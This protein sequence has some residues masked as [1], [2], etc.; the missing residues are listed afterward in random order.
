M[1]FIF[2]LTIVLTLLLAPAISLAQVPGLQNLI[3]GRVQMVE[4]CC[5]GVKIK[6]GDPKGGEFLFMPGLS[7]LYA[8]YNI[9]T[10]GVWVLGTATGIATCQQLL[11]FP[12]CVRPEILRGGIINM[13]GSSGL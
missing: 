7:K 9:F 6:V 3:G 12:P 5:N 8:Y 1:R 10:P 11:S 13:I 4:M 2:N